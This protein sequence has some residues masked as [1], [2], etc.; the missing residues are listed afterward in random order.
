MQTFSDFAVA[1]LCRLVNVYTFFSLGLL[2]CTYLGLPGNTLGSILFSF[3]PCPF[4]ERLLTENFKMNLVFIPVVVTLTGLFGLAFALYGVLTNKKGGGRK[5][6]QQPTQ[7]S[8]GPSSSENKRTFHRCTIATPGCK[9]NLSGHDPHGQ[10]FTCLMLDHDLNNCGPCLTS[11][12]DFQQCRAIRLFL[13]NCEHRSRYPSQCLL[14]LGIT[15]LA[16]QLGSVDLARRWLANWNLAYLDRRASC[17]PVTISPVTQGTGTLAYLSTPSD[18]QP[19]VTGSPR[20][21]AGRS[22]G[23]GL[24]TFEEATRSTRQQ[25]SSATV[26]SSTQ[27]TFADSQPSSLSNLSSS[28]T[29]EPPLSVLSA[30]STASRGESGLALQ[31]HRDLVTSFPP[32]ASELTTVSE[33]IEEVETIHIPVE[34]H[35]VNPTTQG[36]TLSGINTGSFGLS[37]AIQL[38]Q[39]ASSSVSQTSFTNPF[40]VGSFLRPLPLLLNSGLAGLGPQFP[41]ASQPFPSLTR[42]RGGIVPPVFPTLPVNPQASS[43]GSGG[44]FPL[45]ATGSVRPVFSLPSLE[46]QSSVAKPPPPPTVVSAQPP[47]ARAGSDTSFAVEVEEEMD[48]S[49]S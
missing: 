3:P 41:M 26:V 12:A 17:R 42:A 4:S 29:A 47:V 38:G 9:I 11:P 45:L 35:S 21:A 19:Q 13:W 22:P 1:D 6:K 43:M 39:A 28:V 14:C 24:P 44:T 46:P 2:Q 33:R 48:A 34:T 18:S 49:C 23:S 36:F 16:L 27:D 7:P 37:T 25:T 15:R 30:T 31:D 20:A 10:C 40:T 8:K 32:R 5:G